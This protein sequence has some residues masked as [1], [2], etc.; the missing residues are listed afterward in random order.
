MVKQI[1]GERGKHKHAQ[2]VHGRQ[3]FTHDRDL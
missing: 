2:A 1:L 3:K